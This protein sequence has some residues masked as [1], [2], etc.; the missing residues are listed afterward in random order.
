MTKH[1]RKA[2]AVARLLCAFI[3]VL[4]AAS[5]I[6]SDLAQHGLPHLKVATA[7]GQTVEDAVGL[8]SKAL[9]DVQSTSRVLSQGGRS[10]WMFGRGPG[11]TTTYDVVYQD[12]LAPDAIKPGS[13]V[14]LKGV[15]AKYSPFNSGYVLRVRLT[16]GASSVVISQNSVDATIGTFSFEQDLTFSNDRKWAWTSVYSLN[17]FNA[18]SGGQISAS[19]TLSTNQ[20]VG[21]ISAATKSPRAKSNAPIAFATYTAP[22]TVETILIDFSR[23]VTVTVE[24]RGYATDSFELLSFRLVDVGNG[25]RGPPKAPKA[26]IFIG[27][28]LTEGSGSTTNNDLS[29]AVAKLRPGRT[30]VNEG[31]GGQLITSIVDRALADPI[32]GRYGDMV[33]WGGINDVGASGPVW[34]ATV[35]AQINRLVAYRSP[36]SR[37]IILNLH[38]STAWTADQKAAAAYVNAQLAGTYGSIVV[39]VAATINGNAGYYADAIHLNDSGYAAVAAL[40]SAKMAALSWAAN[41]NIQL[42]ANDNEV[43]LKRRL[44]PDAP[45]LE[46]AGRT[47]GWRISSESQALCLLPHARDRTNMGGR[48]ETEIAEEIAAEYGYRLPV[49]TAALAA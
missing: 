28:S 9:I 41:D 27:D 13:S 42:A 10:G 36:T 46:E 40:V 20:A 24:L 37:L 39:D 47:A 30:V 18:P 44:A 43:E 8:A 15:I 19:A 1:P 34:W 49:I 38:E 29:N 5:P 35:Q 45:A 4:I 2:G 14:V 22:P 31:L 33:F 25:Q 11:D 23:A 17:N 16:Q 32:A 6:S 3:A 12:T 21:N 7:A 26:T 48:T